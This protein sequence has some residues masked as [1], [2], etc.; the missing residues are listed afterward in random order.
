MEEFRD[1]Q[2]NLISKDTL[3]KMTSA[4]KLKFIVSEVKLGKVLILEQGLTAAEQ[5][6]LNK[7]TMSEIDHESFI[8]I[9]MPG[10]SADFKKP[11]LFDRIFRRQKTPRMMAI[12]PAKL[13]K[14]IKKEPSLIQT[15]ISP[16]GISTSEDGTGEGIPLD[17]EE[18]DQAPSAIP[19]DNEEAMPESQSRLEEFE[20]GSKKSDLESGSRDELEM[21]IGP[22][23]REDLQPPSQ[24][25][26]DDEEMK[27][28]LKSEQ[29]AGIGEEIKDDKEKEEPEES[30]ST[31]GFILRKLKDEGEE[32]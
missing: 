28:E 18:S 22:E 1:I 6:E 30:D 17:Y 31:K 2:I 24:P 20:A 25:K 9:E 16:G 13:M 14:I 21:L 15:I 3:D 29:A 27:S 5:F 10:F 8:G 11:S 12:G 23:L 7:L 4:E 19:L 32:K 26:D